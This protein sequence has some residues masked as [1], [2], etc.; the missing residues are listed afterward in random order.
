LASV[1]NLDVRALILITE[2]ITSEAGFDGPVVLQ[3]FLLATMISIYLGINLAKDKTNAIA[4][5]LPRGE[6]VS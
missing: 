2:K 1:A 5:G 6:N 3:R 4:A